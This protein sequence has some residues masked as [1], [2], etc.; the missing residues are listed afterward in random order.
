M[1]VLREIELECDC[2]SV[3]AN[4]KEAVADMIGQHVELLGLCRTI[5]FNCEIQPSGV[6]QELFAPVEHVR[7][8]RSR[9]P[10]CPD[11]RCLQVQKL[12]RPA[13]GTVQ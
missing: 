10:S 11:V 7:V 8:E 9:T 5:A 13:P 12:L 1:D 3:M 4:A 2:C 6:L